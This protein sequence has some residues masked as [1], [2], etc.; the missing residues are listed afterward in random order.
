MHVHLRVCMKGGQG[1]V[2]AYERW[3]LHPNE[4]NDK[5]DSAFMLKLKDY[6]WGMQR[7]CLDR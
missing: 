2:T 7:N 5:N 3:T 1:Q 6:L 4:K